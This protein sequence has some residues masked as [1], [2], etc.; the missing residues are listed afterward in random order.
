M[1]IE[2]ISND[3]ITPYEVSSGDD[4]FLLEGFNIASSG[5]G[6]SGLDAI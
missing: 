3:R 5:N 1:P 6:I 4:V 2:I